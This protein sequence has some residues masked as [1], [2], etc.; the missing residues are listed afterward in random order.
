MISCPYCGSSI[1][2]RDN[3]EGECSK[4]G[5]VFSVHMMGELDR[6]FGTELLS[7]V[8]SEDAGRPAGEHSAPPDWY[9]PR[10]AVGTVVTSDGQR[11]PEC[12]ATLGAFIYELT[13]QNPHP[14]R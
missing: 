7:V 4:S 5:A 10:C 14:P 13:E 6:V 8:D 3:G 11:C 1:V 12:D 2:A 9:C